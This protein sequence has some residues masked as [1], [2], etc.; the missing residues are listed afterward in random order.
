MWKETT[1]ALMFRKRKVVA[2]HEPPEH[3]GGWYADP[4][5]TAARRWY[6]SVDGWTDRVEEAGQAPDK[7]GLA[8]TDDAALAGADSPRE[9]G[10][11]GEPLPLSRPVDPKYMANA[12]ATSSGNRGDGRGQ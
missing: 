1:M 11:D 2:H 8:R 10:L 4:W 5:G 6:D 9:L 3:R 12:R 7:T